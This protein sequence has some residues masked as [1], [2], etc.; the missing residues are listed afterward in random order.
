MIKRHRYIKN[1]QQVLSLK[2]AVFLVGARQVGKTSLMKHFQKEFWWVYINFDE[3]VSWLLSFDSLNGFINYLNIYFWI[4]LEK[5]NFIFFDEITR[6]Q[7]F[8]ILFKALKDKY[9]NK[10]YICSASWDYEIVNSI[11]EWLAWRMIKIEV[12]PLTFDEFLQFKWKNIDLNYIDENIFQ[13]IKPFL[14]E[15]LSFGS[16]PEIALTNKVQ[17]KILILK[18]IIDSVFEKDLSYFITK[19]EFVNVKKLISYLAN[20]TGNLFSYENLSETLWIKVKTLK[21][22]LDL[23]EKSYLIYF[24]PPFFTNKKLE[25]SNKNKVY[26]WDFGLINYFLGINHFKTEISWKDA[27]ITSFYQLRFKKDFMDSLYFY[28]KINWTEIDFILEK[29]WKLIPIETK[30]TNKDNIPKVFSFFFKNYQNKVDYFIKTT[31]YK[32]FERE[33]EDKKVIWKPFYS[34]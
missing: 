20:N 10:N 3:I 34:L 30:L 4:D 33:L 18:S 27:E 24:L 22:Y 15:Y 6:I 23:L 16:Y 8:N 25:Y 7:S 1:I 11:I 9:P 2:K 26:M 21:F 13:L 28:R 19:Q 32:V 17:D 5:E 12:F 14:L 31:T 29:K